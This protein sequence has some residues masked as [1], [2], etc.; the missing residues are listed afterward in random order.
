MTERP[1]WLRHKLEAER[2]R[3]FSETAVDRQLKAK[4]AEAAR[5]H[6]RI[7]AQ[8]QALAAEGEMRSS[9]EGATAI[10]ALPAPDSY[11]P[12]T[13]RAGTYR[14]NLFAAGGTEL[15]VPF[16]AD[17]DTDALH[18][19]WLLRDACADICR[20]FALSSGD[21]LLVRNGRSLSVMLPTTW[22]QIT[23]QHQEEVLLLEECL[24]ES[25]TAIAESRTLLQATTLLRRAAPRKT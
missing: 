22:Q 10:T 18:I 15:S 5:L 4:L 25:R 14:L 16:T 13:Y 17:N 23:R 12:G 20:D 24:L 6:H 2:L 21:R 8:L 3:R 7:A 19:A 11:R 1:D 9:A